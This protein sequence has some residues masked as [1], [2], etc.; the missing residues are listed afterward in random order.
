MRYY[1]DMSSWTQNVFPFSDL[2]AYQ[3]GTPQTQTGVKADGSAAVAVTFTTSFPTAC[4]ALLWGGVRA[5]TGTDD[6]VLIPREVNGS[7]TATGFQ[8]VVEGGQPGTTCSV[9]FLPFGN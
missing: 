3:V 6:A 4:I 7:R 2:A 9:D 8:L 1:K 5:Y